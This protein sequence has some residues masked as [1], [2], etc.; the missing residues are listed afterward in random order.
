[1]AGHYFKKDKEQFVIPNQNDYEKLQATGYFEKTYEEVEELYSYGLNKKTYNPQMRLGKKY[2]AKQG[3][4]SEIYGNKD[5]AV[6][7]VNT[8]ERYPITVLEFARDKDKYHP[9]QKPIALFEFL[10]KTY[11]NEGDTIL[12]N[13][14]GVGTTGI[15][16]KNLSRKFIGIEKEPKY[17]EIACQRCGF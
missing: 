4:G 16:S 3:R 9:T 8:G 14:I 11:S 15:A 7:T 17:Y 5:N 12:D 2:T 6:I 10:I 13:C 1:M